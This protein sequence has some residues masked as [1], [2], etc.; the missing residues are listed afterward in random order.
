MESYAIPLSLVGGVVFYAYIAW[1][2]PHRDDPKDSKKVFRNSIGL[3]GLSLALALLLILPWSI[4]E[5]WSITQVATADLPY[6][7]IR[8][9]IYAVY[10]SAA[11]GSLGVLHAAI[12]KYFFRTKLAGGG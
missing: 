5:G 3:L 9:T 10:A 8:T 7:K 2:A 11:A 4:F 1:V 12:A 6:R